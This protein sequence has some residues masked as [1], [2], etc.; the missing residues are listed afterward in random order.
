VKEQ[1]RFASNPP[2]NSLILTKS[3]LAASGQAGN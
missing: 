2:Q 1:G 3:R